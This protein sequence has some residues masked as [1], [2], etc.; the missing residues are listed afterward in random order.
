MMKEDFKHDHES[1]WKLYFLYFN[2]SDKRLFVPKRIKLLGWTLNFA[3]P[4]S[5]F[6]MALIFAFIYYKIHLS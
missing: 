1:N 6:I 4:A 2:S 3:H 5:Y